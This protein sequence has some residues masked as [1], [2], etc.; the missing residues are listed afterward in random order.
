MYQKRTK[1]FSVTHILS[2]PQSN[3]MFSS[4]ATCPV[5]LCLFLYLLHRLV[6]VSKDGHLVYL[7]CWAQKWCLLQK[8]F[9][10]F[11]CRSE[12]GSQLESFFCAVN[13][14]AILS[15][16]ASYKLNL[17]SFKPTGMHVWYSELWFFS[18]VFLWCWGRTVCCVCMFSVL[19][20]L[21][22]RWQFFNYITEC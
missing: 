9:K 12:T 19:C 15:K 21:I 14:V 5:S 20:N 1:T 11:F 13:S 3:H 22:G 17:V 6:W 7:C 8:Q 16:G 18:G 2:L 10:K 4:M